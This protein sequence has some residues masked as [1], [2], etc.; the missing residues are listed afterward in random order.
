MSRHEID[1]YLDGLD[2]PKR[3]TLRQMRDTILSVIPDAE[4]CIS[5]TMPAFRVRGKIIAGFAAFSNHLS[6]LPHSGS[7]FAQ[8]E[9]ELSGYT[10]TKGALHF[11]VETPLPRA[12]VAQL[13][14]VRLR[15]A[16]GAGLEQRAT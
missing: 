6:Y 15:Q 8:L 9:R 5:Y 12:L 11:P 4:E 16:F 13:I 3:T 1:V 14:D 2:E 7:V 10:Q